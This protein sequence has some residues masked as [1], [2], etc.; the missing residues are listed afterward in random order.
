MLRGV[1]TH[2]WKEP[3]SQREIEILRLISDGLSNHE[4]S[5]KLVLSPETIK[6]YN[7]QIFSKLGAHSRTQAVRMAVELGLFG[8]QAI[9]AGAAES[10]PSTNL[11]AQLS[12]FVGWEKEI[13]EIKGLLKSSRLVVLTGPGGCGKTRLA[14]EVATDLVG[15]PNFKDGVFFVS[16][17]SIREPGLVLLTL[18]QTVGAQ[19]TV[20]RSIMEFVTDALNDKHMLLLL[21]NFEQV[22]SAAPL[23]VELLSACPHLKVLVTSRETLH[24]RGEHEYPVPP[25]SLPDLKYLPALQVL[26]Q[27]GAVELFIQRALAVKP[28]FV[29]TDE[30]ASDVAEICARVDCLPLAIELAA[31]RVKLLPPQ[32]MLKRLEH[33][34]TFLTG[35]ARDL[36]ARQQTLRNT[37]DWSYG[38]LNESQQT[39]LNRMSAFVGG[40][41]IE[42]AEIVCNADRILKDELLDLLASLI[43][44]NLVQQVETGG[45]ARFGMLEILREYGLERLDERGEIEEIRR[46]HASYFLAL[47]EQADP[48]LEGP[49][50]ALWV[51]R[52]DHEYGN[53]RAALETFVDNGELDQ[54]LRLGVALWRFWEIRGYLTEGRAW[55]DQLLSLSISSRGTKTRA[56]ALYAAGVLADAQCDYPTARNLFEES[57]AIDREVGEPISLA[58]TLINLGNVANAQGDF[59]MAQSSYTE[60]LEIFRKVGENP[61]QAWALQSLANVAQRQNDFA[62][63]LSMYEETV[64]IWQK[65]GYREPIAVGLIDIGGVLN[66]MGDYRGALSAYEQSL[67]IFQESHNEGAAA[68]SLN[69]LGNVNSTLRDYVTAQKFYM[70]GLEIVHALGDLRGIARFLESLASLA[71]AQAQPERALRLSGAAAELRRGIGAPLHT[72]EQAKVEKTLD[73]ARNSL[74]QSPSNADALVMAG[75][76]MSPEDVIEYALEKEREIL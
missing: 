75:R 60:A 25:L 20:G 16:L 61:G 14:V 30:N 29:L 71:V 39:L 70:T 55:L 28:D 21:D 18:G 3:F 40:C 13:V 56:K 69:L 4:I 48:L 9:T 74:S 38:L 63:A 8:S 2:T 53:M 47:A 27:Y 67:V 59:Q 12:S 15:H 76:R 43:D 22:I 68:I 42:A 65:A 17:A 51:D 64:E 10:R 57:L 34:L 11:P 1:Q 46:S 52:L 45:E 66:A 6:W 58:A 41:T 24:L 35:G 37:I 33:R 44:Q 62:T 23:V 50:Q 26:S 72:T 19:E 36:P 54:A 32:A 73:L 5:Q 31:A 7:K 49:K